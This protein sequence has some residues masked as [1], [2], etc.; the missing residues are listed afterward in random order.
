M[1]SFK[2]REVEQRTEQKRVPIRELKR[3]MIQLVDEEVTK[4]ASRQE[5]S[6]VLCFGCKL[7]H[8]KVHN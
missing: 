5:E 7:S 1:W 4:Q 8:K 6:M 3:K 2:G